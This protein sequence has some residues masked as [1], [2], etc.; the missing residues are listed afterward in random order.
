MNLSS[1]G[2][3]FAP[4]DLRYYNEDSI[5][6]QCITQERLQ[7]WLSMI[8]ARKTLVLLD[9][10][11]SGSF[12][13]APQTRSISQKTAIDKLTRATGRAVISGA[14]SSQAALEGYEGHGVFTYGVLRAL[15]RA[16]K[17]HGNRDGVVTTTEL[18]A[19]VGDE[20]PRMTMER[21]LYEQVP[22]MNLLGTGFPLGAAAGRD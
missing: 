22:Q 9:T 3:H 13:S 17:E 8:Q 15:A 21:W 4:V 20:I 2:H 11:H 1:R 18:A 5:R 7:E 14:S 16:D 6:E 19:Y 10:C 12:V